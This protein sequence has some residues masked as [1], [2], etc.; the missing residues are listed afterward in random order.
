MASLAIWILSSLLAL[1]FVFVGGMKLIG[2]EQV[3]AEFQKFGYPGW[4]RVFIGAAEVAGGVGLLIPRLA[5]LAGAGLVL[6]MLGA[7]YTQVA[8][9]G[10]LMPP[11]I[12]AVLLGVVAYARR[13]G[14][15]SR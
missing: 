2:A 13:P 8:H 15:A 10:S 9:G 4:F 6:I 3:V 12:V 1:L 7:I 5:S 11:F 14:A